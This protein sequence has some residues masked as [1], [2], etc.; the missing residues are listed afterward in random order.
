MSVVP[1]NIRVRREM[2]GGVLYDIGIYCINAARNLF[3]DEPLEASAMTASRPDRR[4]AE[5]DE[6]T[7]AVL[8]F[9]HE[10]LATFSTSFGA[11][12]TS[13]YLVTGTRASLYLDPA[14]DIDEDLRHVYV[15]HGRKSETLFPRRDQ[16]AP[17]LL[18]FSRCIQRDEAPSPDGWEGLADVRVIQALYASAAKG[19]RVA[20]PPIERRPA[21]PTM[22]QEIQKPPVEQKELVGA[23]GPT[24]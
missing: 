23:E 7:S 6:M 5:V 19:E 3:G 1:G 17:E 11:D 24:E 22:A 13:T 2:G 16:F 12:P 8:R 20:L 9:P 15:R 10:R 18:Y 21:M 14:Y 4:F